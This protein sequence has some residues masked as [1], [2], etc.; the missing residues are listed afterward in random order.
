MLE[1]Y[2]PIL[3]F[4]VVGVAVGALLLTVGTLVSPSR[5]DATIALTLGLLRV[6]VAAADEPG[7]KDAGVVDDEDVTGTKERGQLR[8]PGV[9][10]RPGGVV[11]CGLQVGPRAGTVLTVGRAPMASALRRA[12][13]RRRT[14][15]VPQPSPPSADGH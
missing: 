13:S 5:P 7:R 6:S 12:A 1:Q 10:N 8:D 15:S 14:S 4:I 11:P 2:F 9:E 3:L